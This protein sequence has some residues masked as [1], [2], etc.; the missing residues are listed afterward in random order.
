MSKYDSMTK[1]QL[2][3]LQTQRDAQALTTRSS[4][5]ITL[6]VALKGGISAYG[7]GRFPVTLYDEQWRALLNC[8]ILEFLDTNSQ[9]ITDQQAYWDG[10]SQSEKDAIEA[11]RA[12]KSKR[13]P[14]SP[15]SAAVAA[16]QAKHSAVTED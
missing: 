10:L 9:A 7:L 5:G 14:A 4:P 13:K 2:I 16:I 11:E 8:G 6:K 3:A 1:E 15:L 12:A